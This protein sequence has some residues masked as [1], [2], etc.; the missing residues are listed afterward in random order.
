MRLWEGR[1]SLLKQNST[2]VSGESSYVLDDKRLNPVADHKLSVVFWRVGAV[3][4]DFILYFLL[5]KLRLRRM[6]CICGGG[7]WLHLLWRRKSPA[8]VLCHLH[9]VRAL[10]P[11]LVLVWVFVVFFNLLLYFRPLLMWLRSCA[12]HSADE[13]RPSMGRSSRSCIYLWGVRGFGSKMAASLSAI[14]GWALGLLSSSGFK[15]HRYITFCL[16]KWWRC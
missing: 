4:S 3:V 1:A 6:W 16:G 8:F 13:C 5:K 12:L 10:C 2:K 15:R 9:D 14:C 7:C 11:G